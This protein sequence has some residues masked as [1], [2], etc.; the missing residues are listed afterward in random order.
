MADNLVGSVRSTELEANLGRTIIGKPCYIKIIDSYLSNNF[1]NSGENVFLPTVDY[2]TDVLSKDLRQELINLYNAQMGTVK[3][4]ESIPDELKVLQGALFDGLCYGY[5]VNTGK[6]AIYTMNLRLLVVKGMLENL[7]LS[8]DL[9]KTVMTKNKVGEVKCYRIDIEYEYSSEVFSFKAV[10]HRTKMIEVGDDI[11][12]MLIPYIAG[13]R[14]MKMLES[15][16]NSGKVIKTVQIVNGVTKTRCITIN[17]NILKE[18]SDQDYL[19]DYVSPTY[20]PLKGFFYAPVVGASS[21]TAGVT[22]INIFDLCEIKRVADRSA[23]AKLGIEKCSDPIRQL[24]R[25]SVVGTELMKLKSEDLDSYLDLVAS[26]PNIDKVVETTDDM[27]ALTTVGISKYL[28]TITEMEQLSVETILGVTSKIYDRMAIFNV[29]GE[30]VAVDKANLSSEL[31][32]GIFKVLSCSKSGKLTSVVCTNSRSIL[33]KVY[34][35]GYFKKYEGFS[36]KFYAFLGAVQ[37]GTTLSDALVVNGL[38]PEKGIPSEARK[39]MLELIS[40]ITPDDEVHV[41]EL[42]SLLGSLNGARVSNRSSDT[43]SM[44]VRSLD[45]YIDNEGTVHDYYRYINPSEIISCKKLG[46]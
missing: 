19:Y 18:Y 25:E 36:V 42:K 3:G 23:L 17:A 29:H 16:V 13:V 26:L 41:K 12:I 46:E 45:A 6:F 43:G 38:M 28:H 15:I 11:Q 24:C 7:T 22:N 40:K 4:V 33:T 20:F 32:N 30:D 9:L 39:S 37:S 5:D 31:K 1:S 8:T 27:V 10:N 14:L 34:G 44:I 21:L 35:V 2:V